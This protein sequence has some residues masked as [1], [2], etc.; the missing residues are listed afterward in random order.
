VTIQTQA[1]AVPRQR[2]LDETWEQLADGLFTYCL[3]VLCDQDE[4]VAAMRD[5]RRL[6]VRHRRRL[7]Q[8][9]LLRAWMYALARHCC[10]LRMER[11][12]PARREQ[13]GVGRHTV[14]HSHLSR[15]AW[16]EAAG[17]TPAQ[18]EALE[19]SGRHGLDTTELA[20]VL[21]LRPEGARVLLATAVCEVERTAAALIVLDIEDCPELRRLGR[22]RGPVLGPAL[23]G[24]LVRHLDSCP[25]CRGTA[26]RAAAH[27]PWPGT[28]RAPGALPIVPAPAELLRGPV[29]DG[30]LSQFGR[31]DDHPQEP[32]FDRRGFPVHRTGRSERAAALRQRAVAG[33]VIAA[34]VAAPVVAL[35]STHHHR[36]LVEA[37]PVSAISVEVPQT[38]APPPG[39]A[40]TA[41]GGALGPGR[42]GA[43]VGPSGSVNVA[44]TAVAHAPAVS[45]RAAAPP[46]P[47]RLQVTAADVGGRTLI[48]LTDTGG[49][50]L[51]WQAA[52][53]APWLRLSRDQGTLEPQ[54][55]ITV[56]V[57][58]DEALLPSGP[59]TAQVTVQPVGAVVT[60]Q[61]PGADGGR[62][63][64]PTPSQTPTPTPTPTPSPTPSSSPSPSPSASASPSASPSASGSAPAS[65]PASAAP[66]GRHRRPAG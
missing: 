41:P 66:Q 29:A 64:I 56:L 23:R 58:V 53:P 49:T 31:R 3:S 40:P 30:F 5:V 51:T 61:G 62:R 25:T 59:W 21:D 44:S 47:A 63:G 42:H 45:S 1:R 17:T 4:A 7:R 9:A 52:T 13:Q 24:E 50:A 8:P 55:R 2:G 60:L 27:G 43:G 33:S 54:G 11:D 16:P 32:R 15:L 10:L 57:T 22:G 19:L 28:L 14:R 26:E 18:R 48:T 38:A 12:E 35:W 39:P 34:V 65:A 6:S 46:A 36:H 37:D 20:A